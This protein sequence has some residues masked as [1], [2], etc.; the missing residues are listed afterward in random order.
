MHHQRCEVDRRSV[1]VRL[2]ERGRHVRQTVEELFERHAEGLQKRNVLD[3][4]GIDGINISLRRVER[5][6][7]DQIRYIY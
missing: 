2:T 7:K 4:A 3:S 1:R 6:W 5:Y